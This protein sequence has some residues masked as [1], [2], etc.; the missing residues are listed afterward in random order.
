M[1]VIKDSIWKMKLK[2][3]LKK[4]GNYLNWIFFPDTV[5]KSYEQLSFT[6]TFIAFCNAFL[7]WA[8]ISVFSGK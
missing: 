2:Q 6:R 5:S 4:K 8:I 1:E 7:Q 3:N